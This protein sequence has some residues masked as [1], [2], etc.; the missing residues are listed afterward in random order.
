MKRRVAAPSRVGLLVGLVGVALSLVPGLADAGVPGLALITA[1]II[2]SGFAAFGR[3]GAATF[4]AAL[5]IGHVAIPVHASVAVVLLTSAVLS[6]FLA[7]ADIAETQVWRAGWRPVV[8]AHAWI[9]CAA[10]ASAAAVLLTTSTP[11]PQSA[12]P[13]AALAGVAAAG[14]LVWMASRPPSPPLPPG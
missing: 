10:T 14:S 5:V 2:G 8:G 9:A 12:A 13:I 7:L 4:V 1:G 6:Q 11:V 3:A